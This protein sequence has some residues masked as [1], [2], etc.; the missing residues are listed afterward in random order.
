VEEFRIPEYA[1]VNLELDPDGGYEWHAR[2]LHIMRAYDGGRGHFVNV[3]EQLRASEHEGQLFVIVDHRSRGGDPDPE[4][5]KV[6]PV[7]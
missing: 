1:H 2:E 3:A 7:L 4:V 5:H 6:L